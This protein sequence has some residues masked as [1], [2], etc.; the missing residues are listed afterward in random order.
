MSDDRLKNF[1]TKEDLEQYK[2][3]QSI[4]SVEEMKKIIT[5]ETQELLKELN[6][7]MLEWLKKEKIYNVSL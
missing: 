3:Y 6:I 4:D 5:E 7:S 2:Q 1:F